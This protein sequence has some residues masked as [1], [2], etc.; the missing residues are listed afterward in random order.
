MLVGRDADSL[1]IYLYLPGVRGGNA[2]QK[3]RRVRVTSQAGWKTLDLGGEGGQ[4]SGAT[5]CAQRE[6]RND[7]RSS[8]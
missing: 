3:R 8:N 1:A 7:N 6:M 5:K 2:G 4:L